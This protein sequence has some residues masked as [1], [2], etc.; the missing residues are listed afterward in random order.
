MIRI[1]ADRDLKAVAGGDTPNGAPTQIIQT[2]NLNQ[3][4]G[5]IAPGK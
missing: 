3:A 5:V 2:C 1:L 4:L